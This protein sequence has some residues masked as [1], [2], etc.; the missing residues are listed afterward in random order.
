MNQVPPFPID[1]EERL[2]ALRRYRILDTEP[3][4]QFDRIVTLAKR[5]FDV[6]MAFVSFVDGDREFL[7]APLE[8]PFRNVPREHSF[9]A[10][11][12]L[13]DEVLVVLDATRDDRF[14]DNPLVVGDFNIRFYAGAPLIASSGHRL[15]TV[16]LVDVHPHSNFSERDKLDLADLASVVSDY[17]EMRLIIGDVHDEIAIR[18]AAEARAHKLAY[19]DV[20]TGLP[21]RAFLQ[22]VAAE[23]LP[24]ERRGVLAVLA[25]DLD[26]FKTVND[27]FGHHAGDEL[28]RR[29]ASSLRTR[30]G[31]RA[32]V[33]RI[34]GDEFVAVLDGDSRESVCALASAIVEGTARPFSLAGRMISNGVSLGIAFSESETPDVNALVRNADLALCVAKRAGR[35]QA[36]VFDEKMAIETRRL[37]N[38]K[39]DLMGA[40]KNNMIAVLFQPIHRV[41]DGT[42]AGVEALARW[43]HPR[44][45][46]VSP[47]EFI[48]LA[49]ESGQI[50]ELG[51]HILRVALNAARDW[52]EIAYVSVNLSPVQFRLD[53]LVPGVAAILAET[54][55]PAK[56][57]QLEVTESVLFDDCAGA[58]RQMEALL[59]I[60]VRVALDDFGTGYSGLNYL[61]ELPFTKVKIDRSFV[62]GAGQDRK[63]HAII[64]HIVALARG[65]DMTV[66]AEGVETEDEA[67]LASAAGC[68]SLQGHYFG[69]A[70]GERLR[71][72]RSAA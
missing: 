30:L 35:R 66:T 25:A 23:G 26:D 50:L 64:R 47:T 24:F 8:S 48:A 1:E 63:R 15:G 13:D 54:G 12:I 17:L 70:I 72:G 19:H 34:S 58:K 55:V 9:C 61:A 4:P 7:K 18:R 32:F 53:D 62:K 33:A 37:T 65:L 16:C 57:L 14:A 5:R 31:E 67:A 43:N 11:T 22:K 45:G 59:E 28:L 21:N 49:E 20:L 10:Y 71:R 56:R 52:H 40:V 44:I 46:P 68:T 6:P 2:R 42:M 3:E 60:G 51:D 38:L 39:H 41:R 36:A 27:T 29:T 69:S